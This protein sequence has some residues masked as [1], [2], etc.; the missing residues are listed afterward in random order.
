MLD[1]NKLNELGTMLYELREARVEDN[2]PPSD[3]NDL[4]ADLMNGLETL[5][6]MVN[7]RLPRESK[8]QAFGS[9][10]VSV[11]K[12]NEPKRI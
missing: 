5:F 4:I 11:S 7:A 9:T 3:L 1:D 2:P 12:P 10:F 6:I 8:P